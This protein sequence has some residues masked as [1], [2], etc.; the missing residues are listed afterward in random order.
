[1]AILVGAAV[2]VVR[3]VVTSAVLAN[4]HSGAGAAKAVANSLAPRTG[5]GIHA[6]RARR[7]Q[8]VNRTETKGLVSVFEIPLFS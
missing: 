6:L 1:M 7:V 4:A 2:P 8:F 3:E 5:Y